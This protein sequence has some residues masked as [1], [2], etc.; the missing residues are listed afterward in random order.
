MS[1]L[2]KSP[3]RRGVLHSVVAP[4]PEPGERLRSSPGPS[5]LPGK[6]LRPAWRSPAASTVF[7]NL[8]RAVIW[9]ID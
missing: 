7:L 3:S 5:R 4:V 2:W 8:D 1:E 6:R 9:Q